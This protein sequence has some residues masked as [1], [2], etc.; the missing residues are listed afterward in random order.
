MSSMAARKGAAFPSMYLRNW[1][2]KFSA[3]CT[4]DALCSEVSVSVLEFYW[5]HPAVA[6]EGSAFDR[7]K[8]SW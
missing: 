1:F 5:F 6:A 2:P 3:G 4:T 8:A 7:A